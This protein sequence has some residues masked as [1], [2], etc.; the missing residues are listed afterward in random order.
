M[1]ERNPSTPASLV[2]GSGGRRL[3][4]QTWWTVAVIFCATFIAY[5]PAL[6]GG[7]IWD[8]NGHV[9]RLALR[10]WPG[11]WRIW[12]ELGATQQY[13]PLLHSAFWIEHRLWGDATVGYH[14]VTLAL[15]ICA[16]CLVALILRRLA[17]PGAF[18]A[19][20]IFALH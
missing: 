11:L 18:L 4:S 6:S 10:S 12:F 2:P 15:H 16:A 3:G 19:A 5:F 1:P 8:D 14:L 17:I 13:Y 9:T 7:F 20:M